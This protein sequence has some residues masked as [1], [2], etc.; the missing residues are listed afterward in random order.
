MHL[1]QC[2]LPLYDNEKRRYPRSM[3]EAETRTLT[4]LFGG[5]TA[6]T[7]APAS[8]LWNEGNTGATHDEFII[9]EVMVNDLDREWW[10]EYRRQLEERFRQERIIVRTYEIEL[11]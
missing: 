7:Q 11:L 2:F 5:M 3:Y 1:V 10:R 6:Y 9:Y 8:G 4:Q